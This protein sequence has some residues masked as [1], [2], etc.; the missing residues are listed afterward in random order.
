MPTL[1]KKGTN[2]T[3]TLKRRKPWKKAYAKSPYKKS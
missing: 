3:K 2:I 1:R